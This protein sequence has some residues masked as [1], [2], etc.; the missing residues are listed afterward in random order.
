MTE[1]E[2]WQVRNRPDFAREVEHENLTVGLLEIADTIMPEVD[3]ALDA[4]FMAHSHAMASPPFKERKLCIA[5]RDVQGVIVAAL[6]GRTLWNWLYVDQLWV[7]EALRGQGVGSALMK[8]AEEEAFKRGCVG[9][10]LWTQT[11]D[12]PEFYAKLGCEVY[13]T[14]DDF[15]IGHQRFG[16]RKRLI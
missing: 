8:A 16:F 9:V 1:K 12:A 14:F 11:F 6:T 3:N 15:P 7:D 5:R 13:A 10:Y 2:K 4:G